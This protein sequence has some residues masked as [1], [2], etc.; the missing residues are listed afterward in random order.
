MAASIPLADQ[1]NTVLRQTINDLRDKLNLQAGTILGLEDKLRE[2][3]SAHADSMRALM[4]SDE[5]IQSKTRELEII[6]AAIKPFKTFAV[7]HGCDVLI[8][9]NDASLSE[10]DW[11]ALKDIV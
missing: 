4:V 10:E 9:H 8:G 5:T 1:T 11:E 7:L 2:V 3:H 6:K